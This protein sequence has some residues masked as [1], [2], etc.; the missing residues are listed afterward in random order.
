ML[1]FLEVVKVI[2]WYQLLTALTHSFGIP[3]TQ[4]LGPHHFFFCVGQQVSLVTWLESRWWDK[5]TDTVRRMKGLWL[6]RPGL[7]WWEAKTPPHKEGLGK[8][9]KIKRLW[10][11][12]HCRG[13]TECQERITGS[14]DEKK[15]WHYPRSLLTPSPS[16]SWEP[17]KEVSFVRD[18]WKKHCFTS[19]SNIQLSEH[20]F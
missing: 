4:L 10:G 9:N 15:K 12:W 1:N 20:T 5:G 6:R 13:N 17:L 8:E 11:C 3:G 14:R 19:L 7:C 16:V 2:T 18:F